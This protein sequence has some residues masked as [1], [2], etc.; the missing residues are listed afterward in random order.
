MGGKK[1]Q[2]GCCGSV[3]HTQHGLDVEEGNQA[4]EELTIVGESLAVVGEVKRGGDF[5]YSETEAS[6]SHSAFKGNFLL[7]FH[8]VFSLTSR[9]LIFPGMLFSMVMSRQCLRAWLSSSPCSRLSCSRHAL[10]FS[11]VCSSSDRRFPF[12]SRLQS[13]AISR[14]RPGSE[15]SGLGKGPS[16]STCIPGMESLTP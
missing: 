11:T 2:V 14:T 12:S 7:D 5:K 9:T 4:R 13:R 8:L 10:S 15:F 6:I 3:I 1:V 16:D